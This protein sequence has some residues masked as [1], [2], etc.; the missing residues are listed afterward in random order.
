MKKLSFKFFGII[1]L[2]GLILGSGCDKQMTG[3]PGFLEGK[4]TIG[5]LC[6]AESV[7]PAPE[8]LP[9]AETYKAYPVSVW[10]ANGRLKIEQIYPSLDGFFSFELAPGNYLVRLEKAQN[11]IGSSSNLPV[12][13]VVNPLAKTVLNIDIDTGIR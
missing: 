12:E 7:P 5:P 3:D 2:T 9:T 13:V 4:I 6:P 8:C 1:F 10:T 11:T